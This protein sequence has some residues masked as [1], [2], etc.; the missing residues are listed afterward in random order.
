MLRYIEL[1]SGQNDKGPAWIARVKLSRSGNT[2]YFDDRALKRGGAIAGNHVDL[3]TGE[4]YW[5]SGVKKDGNDRHWAGSG[6]TLIEE[7]AVAEYLDLVGKSEID[8]SS[9][10]I[11]DDLPETNIQRFVDIENAG[12]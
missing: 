2:V 1:K 8:N 3:E 11:I 5:I 12:L 7:S 10:V 4:E 9:L 6:K